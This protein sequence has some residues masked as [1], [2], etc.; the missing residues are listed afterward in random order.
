MHRHL[1]AVRNYD[2]DEPCERNKDNNKWFD[3]EGKECTKNHSWYQWLPYL[4]FLQV[5]WYF[6][7]VQYV[8]TC[9]EVRGRRSTDDI[10]PYKILEIVAVEA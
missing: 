4:F 8:F 1:G 10:R 9:D 3:S 7:I 6:E 2:L 5:N